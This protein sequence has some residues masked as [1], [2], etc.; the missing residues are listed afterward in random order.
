MTVNSQADKQPK[1][2][3]I[4]L[5]VDDSTF[6]EALLDAVETEGGRPLVELKTAGV[7]HEHLASVV[8]AALESHLGL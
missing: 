5:I 4:D 2:Y 8:R 7:F 1:V 3:R 6:D